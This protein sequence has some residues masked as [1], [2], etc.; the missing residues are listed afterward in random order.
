MTLCATSSYTLDIA[1]ACSITQHIF[2]LVNSLSVLKFPL[3]GKLLQTVK[4][5][6]FV[7][8]HHPVEPLLFSPRIINY[9]QNANPPTD[10]GVCS[11]VF[12]VATVA[13]LTGA[14]ELQNMTTVS[15]TE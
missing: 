2:I 8:Q 10:C 3:S 7:R 6:T 14:P 11:T 9:T 13:V 5:L 4:L 12:M 1:L 15:L